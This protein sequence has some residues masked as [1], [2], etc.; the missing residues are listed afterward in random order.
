[1]NIAKMAPN[2][3][4]F[5]DFDNVALVSSSFA[6]EVIGKLFTEVGPVA[7]MS[8]FQLVSVMPTVRSLTA[9]ANKSIPIG[10]AIIFLSCQILNG[11]NQ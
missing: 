7:F 6:D 10:R 1:M 9:P 8:R 5:I 3:R 2:S 4:I 11:C